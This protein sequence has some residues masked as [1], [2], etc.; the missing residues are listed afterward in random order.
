MWS[1]IIQRGLLT[2]SY[3]YKTGISCR[4]LLYD[5]SL[6][7]S[8]QAPIPIISIGNLL[9]GGTGKTPLVKLLAERLLSRWKVAILSRGYGGSRQKIPLWVTPKIPVTECGD[10]PYWLA[11]ELPQATV[12]VG[13][14]RLV[15][16]KEAF[17]KHQAQLALLD[18]G[19][20][21][22]KLKRD[23]EIVIVDTRGDLSNP[24]FLPL[25]LFRELPHRLQCA[26]FIVIRSP[27]SV[28]VMEGIQRWS[29]A[30][31]IGVEM[32]TT[33]PETI[34]NR[35]VALFCAIGN[36]IEF[37]RSIQ[38]T[39]GKVLSTLFKRDHASFTPKEIDRFSQQERVDYLIC[40]EKDYVKLPAYYSAPVPILVAKG[41]LNICFGIETWEQMIDQIHLTTTTFS[42][43][44]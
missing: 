32:I 28:P 43:G 21:H 14:N 39:G 36:P 42:N 41:R 30:P 26:D 27:F 22:R 8:A 23:L 15:S 10:E 19:M 5:Q 44:F 16:A 31:C 13:A 29:S 25:G 12:L 11:R 35:K 24:K 4:H 38:K 17:H 1:K 6:I 37:L 40:T 7:K 34:R 20:Q 18:D 2:L 3:L 9:A 33:L